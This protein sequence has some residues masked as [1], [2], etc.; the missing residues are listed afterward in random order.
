MH[1]QGEELAV[2][3][4]G[5]LIQVWGITWLRKSAQVGG[6]PQFSSC[7]REVHRAGASAGWENA[8]L[9][10]GAGVSTSAASSACPSVVLPAPSSG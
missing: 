7:R 10:G 2:G 8:V 1:S 3:K 6:R 9:Q 5:M 4:P